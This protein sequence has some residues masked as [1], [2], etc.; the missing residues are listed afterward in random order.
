MISIGRFLNKAGNAEIASVAVQNDLSCSLLDLIN[1][2]VLSGD[3]WQSLRLRVEEVKN[4]IHSDP[5]SSSAL[6]AENSVS[7]I[8]TEYVLASQQADIKQAIEMQHVFAM[9]NQVVGVLA[10]GKNRSVSRLNDI[11]Q[12]LQR[13][14]SLRDIDALRSSLTDT[15]LFVKEESK[16]EQEVGAETLAGFEAE[17]T[18]SREFLGGIKT[19]LPGRPEG[20]IRVAEALKIVPQGEALYLVAFVFD[21]LHAVVHRHGPAVADELFFRL[22]KE[23]LLLVAPADAAYRWTP[24]GL[25]GIFHRSADLQ[26]L[27]AE[28]ANLNRNPLVHRTTVG[29]RTAVLTMTPSHLVIEGN[30]ERP[31]A[32]IEQVDRFAGLA[33]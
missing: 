4:S 12:S 8:L 7:R 14:S 27:R 25:V 19:E 17:V 6:Q 20:V 24:G 18:R 31:E 26:G 16:R 15:I 9:L 23:R 11:Q 33:A 1:K 32:L 10:D 29:G 30:S 2:H 3:D 13:A 21:R 28:V 22:I 5:E